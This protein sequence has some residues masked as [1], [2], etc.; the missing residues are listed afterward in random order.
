MEDRC[1]YSDL[2]HDYCGHCK[3]LLTVEEEQEE[4]DKDMI[5]LGERFGRDD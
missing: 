3:G 2:P 5:K 1:P 4:L